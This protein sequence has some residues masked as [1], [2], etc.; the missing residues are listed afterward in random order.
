LSGPQAGLTETV[1]FS[2]AADTAVA[3]AAPVAARQVRA[4]TKV[5][6]PHEA[7]VPVADIPEAPG[8][9]LVL[10]AI[11]LAAYFLRRHG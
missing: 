7:L 11:A 5:H 9:A 3:S 2:A 10:V 8:W 4:E 1:S 6:P